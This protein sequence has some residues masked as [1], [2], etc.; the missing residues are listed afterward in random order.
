MERLPNAETGFAG[1]RHWYQSDGLDS[2][3]ALTD[4]SGDLASPFLYDEYGQMLAGSTELQVFAYTAQDYDVETGLVHFYARYYDAGRGVWL[5]LDPERGILWNPLTLRRYQFV[6]NNPVNLVDVMGFEPS[7]ELQNVTKQIEKQEKYLN[8]LIVQLYVT[9]KEINQMESYGTLG[10]LL[11]FKRLRELR[12]IQYYL[13]ILTK[14][15]IRNIEELKEERARLEE[16]LDDNQV[17]NNHNG[18]C[19]VTEWL[20]DGKTFKITHYALVSE[21]D[22]TS[23]FGTQEEVDVPGLPGVKANKDFLYSDVGVLMQGSGILKNGQHIMI[24]WGRS[25]NG[26]GYFKY[27]VGAD[28][29]PW[30]TVATDVTVIPRGSQICIEIY[31]NRGAFRATDT[32]GDIQG[33]HIDVFVNSLTEAFQQGTKWSKVGLLQQNYSQ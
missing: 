24:D 33:R 7:D 17:N 19:L 25:G 18:R 14:S 9:S 11:F 10:E 1:D 12:K 30:K 28:V 32:G 15:T 29:V 2:V 4:E 22:D 31:Q 16:S 5:T 13:K 21:R 27:G 23:Y 26:T 8:Y 6:Y 3:V 20:E